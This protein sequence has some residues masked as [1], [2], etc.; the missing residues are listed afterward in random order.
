[1]IK[2]YGLRLKL[3]WTGTKKNNNNNTR[4]LK[5]IKPTNQP[6]KPTNHTG[7]NIEGERSQSRWAAKSFVPRSFRM[8]QEKN[9]RLQDTPC[10][11]HA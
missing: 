6:M 7:E 9:K 1:M 2:D 11:R 5:C 4:M 10:M 3:N 8:D